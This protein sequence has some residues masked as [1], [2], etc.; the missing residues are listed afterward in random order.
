MEETPTKGTLYDENANEVKEFSEWRQ[1]LTPESPK[2]P[3]EPGE[4]QCEA[5]NKS[6]CGVK[7]LSRLSRKRR[8]FVVTKNGRVCSR[9]RH[10]DKELASSHSD[11]KPRVT[12]KGSKFV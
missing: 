3:L 7:D 4:R 12:K 1:P 10:E 5:P 6:V 9:K 11:T 8:T 2:S